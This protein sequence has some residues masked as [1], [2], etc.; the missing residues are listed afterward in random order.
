M[1]LDEGHHPVVLFEMAVATRLVHGDLAADA[2]E[3]ERPH[4]PNVVRHG[5]AR[6]SLERA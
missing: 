5:R 6:R 4:H 3:H 1:R 2:L